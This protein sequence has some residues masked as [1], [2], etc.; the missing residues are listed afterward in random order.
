MEKQ[1]NLTEGMRHCGRCKQEFPLSREFF[2]ADASRNHGLGYECRACHSERKLGRDNRT[3]R[4][5]KLT[6]DQKVKVKAR[7]KRY[8]A[9]D[10]GR[11]VFLKKAYKRI[12]A[13]DMT[14]MEVLN[15]IVQPCRYCGTTTS[16]RGLDRIDNSKPHIKGNVVQACAPCNFARGDRF[17]MDEMDQ[18]GAVIRK[19]MDTRAKVIA[20][21][22]RP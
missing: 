7:Q 13:C 17:T 12:D 11:A 8:N 10:K 9:T 2:V 22:D 15:F 3:D 18:I 1:K 16:P 19:I 4:W 6:P 21:E 5:Y 20:S 14:T